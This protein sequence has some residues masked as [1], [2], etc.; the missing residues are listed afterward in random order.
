[1]EKATMN[2]LMLEGI[3]GG[4]PLGFLAALGAARLTGTFCPELQLCWQPESGAWRPVFSGCVGDRQNYLEQLAAAMASA[5]MEPF[6]IDGKLPFPVTLFA[7]QIREAQ[8]HCRADNR[9][10]ADFLAAFGSEIQPDKKKTDFQDTPFRM[11]RSGD[12]AGQGLPAYARAIRQQA[13]LKALERTLFKPWDYRDDAFSLRWDPLEDQRYALRW[14]NPS[15]ANL[16]DGPG[17]MLGANSLALE[18]LPLF[19]VALTAT[20]RIATTGFVRN[21]QREVFFTWPIWNQ[22]VSLETVRSLLS[23]PELNDESVARGKLAWRGV[24]EIYR[25]QRIAQNQYY[26][27]FTPAVPA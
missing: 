18:A 12:A 19:P 14:K 9:R 20:S 21:R 23:L 15:K 26:S 1:M 17:T 4:N 13:D 2:E 7:E 6:A 8:V 16:N 27:N 22:P 24:V 3:D 25:S 5:S 10:T 11:V